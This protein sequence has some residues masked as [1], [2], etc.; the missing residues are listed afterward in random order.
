MFR[1]NE[2]GKTILIKNPEEHAIIDCIDC[3][4]EH[5]INGTELISRQLGPSEE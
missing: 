1:C 5:E 2:C 4:M 3:G